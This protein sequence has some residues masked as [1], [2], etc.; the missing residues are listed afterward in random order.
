MSL[1]IRLMIWL[2][3]YQS[4]YLM[5]KPTLH[6]NNSDTTYSWDNKRV[7]TFPKGI[8]PKMNA[9]AQLEFELAFFEAA[10]QHF[11]H[12]T[13][14]TQTRTENRSNCF[15]NVKEPEI[16]LYFHLHHPIF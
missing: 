2:M 6:K 1:D 13:T 7:H 10:D 14:G 3:A 4:S 12:Y 9:I 16:C 11:S 8:S 15:K 5:P